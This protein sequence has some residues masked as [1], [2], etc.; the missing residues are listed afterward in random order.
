M[1]VGELSG[2][3]GIE[4]AY[5]APNVP[6]IY[7]WYAYLRPGRADWMSENAGGEAKASSNLEGMLER[8]SGKFSKQKIEIEA[9]ANFSLE[10]K[11]DLISDPS[12]RFETVFKNEEENPTGIRKSFKNSISSDKKREAFIGF[13]KS[14]ETFFSAPLYLGLATDQPLRMR[15]DNHRTSYLRLWD[16]YSK[17]EEFRYRLESEDDKLQGMP[18]TYATRAAHVGYGF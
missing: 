2:P 15:L 13:L 4:D 11:G 17:D 3:F 9:K 6:G 7:V 16:V 8:F 14:S 18:P 1:G 10:W 5:K 12:S